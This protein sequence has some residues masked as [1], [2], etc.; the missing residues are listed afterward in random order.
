MH[1][2]PGGYLRAASR[3]ESRPSNGTA[4]RARRG[5][6]GS[7]DIQGSI[8]HLFRLL[9]QKRTPRSL[10]FTLALCLPRLRRRGAS[11]SPASARCRCEPRREPKRDSPGLGETGGL[12][13]RRQLAQRFRA[14]AGNDSRLRGADLGHLQADLATPADDRGHR[15]P[16]TFHRDDDLESPDADFGHQDG[17]FEPAIA[18]F[19]HRHADSGHR[20]DDLGHS[21]AERGHHDGDFG[22]Q[23]DDRGH[24]PADLGHPAGDR[25]HHDARERQASAEERR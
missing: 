23:A 16:H 11:A 10:L 5:W 22:S 4:G 25:G 20:H 7:A 8:P 9:G 15:Q 21:L 6:L 1:G 24:H 19:D 18:D 12:D 17:D 13:R 3:R 2:S 14:S